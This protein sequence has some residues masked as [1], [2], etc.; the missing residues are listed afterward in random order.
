MHGAAGGSY[1]PAECVSLISGPAQT[2]GEFD[3][4]IDLQLFTAMWASLPT[5]VRIMRICQTGM[6]SGE[7]PTGQEVITTTP[8]GGNVLKRISINLDSRTE[9]LDPALE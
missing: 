2:G 1:V 3:F 9:L 5:R 7:S 6:T 8:R 4:G